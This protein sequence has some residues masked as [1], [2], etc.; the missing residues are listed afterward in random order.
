MITYRR[1]YLSQWP[2]PILRQLKTLRFSDPSNSCMYDLI[3]KVPHDQLYTFVAFDGQTPIGWLLMNEQENNLDMSRTMYYVRVR[4]RRRGIATRLFREICKCYE[5]N[6]LY[7]HLDARDE[8]SIAFGKK[9]QKVGRLLWT[10]RR[11]MR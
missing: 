7:S 5:D 2:A 1:K 9:I 11:S 3:K 10:K 6:D 8:I 4:Y